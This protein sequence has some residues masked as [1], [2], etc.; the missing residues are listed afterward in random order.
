MLSLTFFLKRIFQGPNLLQQYLAIRRAPSLI[1]FLI[2]S[3]TLSTMTLVTSISSFAS[4]D[5]ASSASPIQLSGYIKNYG[6]LHE[7]SDFSFTQADNYWQSQNS[8]R[9]M[10]GYSN[11][12][13]AFK[14]I[15]YY[16][17]QVHYELQNVT[18]E[19]GT[20]VSNS[21]TKQFLN[22]SE[23]SDV[24][25]ASDLNE[26]LD[27]NG[28]H[29][30][31]YQNL[32]RLNLQLRFA[33]SD[34]TLGRQA[35]SLGAAR[36]I[37]PSDIFIPQ[38]ITSITDEYR[39][40]IDALRFQYA[41]NALAEFDAG[42]LAGHDFKNNGAW[43]QLQIPVNQNDITL[44]SALTENDHLFGLGVQS[45]WKDIGLWFEG[46]SIEGDSQSYFR[47]SSGFDYS[48]KD[49]LFLQVEHHHN[50]I[51]STHPENYLAQTNTVPWQSH[52]VFLLGRDYLMPSITWQASALSSI[53][54][55]VI[56][57]IHDHSFLLHSQLAYSLSENCYADLGA[58]IY[59]GEKVEQTSP[60]LFTPQS[61]FGLASNLI[62][63]SVRFYL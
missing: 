56:S 20:P 46:A 5:A 43:V 16:S 3:L 30:I 38:N 60:L 28:E 2:V 57:N 52:G 50:S 35:I 54:L 51:A 44:I 36:N 29:V 37:N 53:N 32:D 13:N 27:Q 61:E 1:N 40:G 59:Q 11:E 25:R 12:I 10:L 9:V 47:L 19:S 63:A 15:E 4:T 22:A 58:Y 33:N 62:F 41:I 49:D 17:V 6:I 48:I 24:Y 34:L 31:Y 55:Q 21:N 26:V 45:S 23:T 7:G 8:A 14:T 18:N 39:R 42:A